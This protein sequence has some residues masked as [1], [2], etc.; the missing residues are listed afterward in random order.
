MLGRDSRPPCFLEYFE[1]VATFFSIK[2]SQCYHAVI[3]INTV[4]ATAA[5]Q[6]STA[7]TRSA[8]YISSPVS[9]TA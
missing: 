8:P 7:L 1:D 3:A 5:R 9:S 2:A 6:S 4:K